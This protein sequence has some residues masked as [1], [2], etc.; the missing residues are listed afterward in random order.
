MVRDPAFIAEA[1]KRRVELSPIDGK[2]IVAAL[3][4]SAATPRAVVERF[5]AI[6]DPQH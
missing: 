6:V 3:A 4:R 2:G 1:G 5:N